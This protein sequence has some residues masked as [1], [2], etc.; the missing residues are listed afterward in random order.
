MGLYCLPQSVKLVTE[1][2]F[3]M[4]RL[5]ILLIF[6]VWPSAAYPRVMGN[7]TRFVS[8]K[9]NTS[10]MSEE[11]ISQAVAV[12]EGGDMVIQ[13]QADFAWR[14]CEITHVS[15]GRTCTRSKLPEKDGVTVGLVRNQCDD[16]DE[17]TIELIVPSDVH[18]KRCGI[19][20]KRVGTVEV[21][22][23]ICSVKSDV[24]LSSKSIRV[25]LSRWLSSWSKKSW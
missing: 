21:G 20:V 15:S 24:Q 22:E 19:H 4:A 11:Q 12:V 14:F 23:W 3:E 25:F 16:F 6:A 1:V 10:I 5:L 8:D 13:C 2:N 9:K 18:G 17:G 7:I